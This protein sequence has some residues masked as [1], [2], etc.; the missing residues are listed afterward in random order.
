MTIRR[1]SVVALLALVGVFVLAAPALGLGSIGADN[2]ENETDE[3]GAGVGAFAQSTAESANGSVD[4]G[5]WAAEVNATD[6]QTEAVGERVTVLEQRLDRLETAIAELEAE[7]E[8]GTI[9]EAAYQ[10]RAAALQTQLANVEASLDQT[11]TVGQRIGLNTTN[12][13]LLRTEA[14]NMSGPEVAAVA[15][16][17][18]DAP[19]GPPGDVGAANETGPPDDVE[20]GND[21]ETGPPED[22][23]AD[24]DT[25]AGPPEDSGDDDSEAG[26]PE[27]N[28]TGAT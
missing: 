9:T 8:A 21:T 2:P 1:A 17:I 20:P 6:N 13:E 28:E 16:T 11:A 19:R 5:M 27:D 26:P 10:A 3:L 15:Q 23:G 25:D 18:T 12:I 24:N 7:R 14:A 4:R 22:A